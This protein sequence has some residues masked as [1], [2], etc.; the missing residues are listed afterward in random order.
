M[1]RKFVLI[2]FG[3]RKWENGEK[4][5]KKKEKESKKKAKTEI[6]ENGVITIREIC[7]HRLI[8]WVLFEHWLKLVW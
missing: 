5:R 1:L 8:E 6:E 2:K 4:E 7:L 3:S